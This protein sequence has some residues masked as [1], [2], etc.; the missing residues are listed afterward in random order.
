MDRNETAYLKARADSELE[1]AQQATHPAAVRAH[2]MLAGLYL[3]RLYGSVVE[4]DLEA[5]A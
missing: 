1:L 4:T 2:Y 5:R 3:D